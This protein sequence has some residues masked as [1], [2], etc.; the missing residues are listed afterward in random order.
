M[1]KSA[2]F[3]KTLIISIIQAWQISMKLCVPCTGY[4]LTE[5]SPLVT[6]LQRGN[7]NLN[8]SGIPIPNTY[9]KVVN[10]D[11]GVNVGQGVVGELCVMGPQ[12]RTLV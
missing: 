6:V 3:S 9:V 8:S 1:K 11:T 7:T 4:G 5:T 2:T 10:M 12:V